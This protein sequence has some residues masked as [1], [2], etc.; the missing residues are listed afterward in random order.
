MSV[1]H[2]LPEA[3]VVMFDLGLQLEQRRQAMGM[4][5][6]LPQRMAHPYQSMHNAILMFSH[7]ES[8]GKL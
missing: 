4:R 1:Q 2:F 7:V 5:S 8:G 6:I 3:Q